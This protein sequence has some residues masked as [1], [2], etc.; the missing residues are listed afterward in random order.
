VI[1]AAARRERK[2]DGDPVVAITTQDLAHGFDGLRVGGNGDLEPADP[3]GRRAT[4][5]P[6]RL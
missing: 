4:R 2:L 3:G 1:R 6:S 5:R